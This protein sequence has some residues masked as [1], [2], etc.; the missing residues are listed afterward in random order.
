MSSPHRVTFVKQLDGSPL[1]GLSCTCA[2]GAMAL[3]RETIGAKRT[4]GARVRQLT[5]DSSGGTTLTQVVAAL[6]RG[7]SVSLT[8][9]TPTSIADFDNRLHA[10]QGAILQGS[11]S[12]TRG[13]RYQASETFG[14]NHAWFV[15]QGRGWRLTMGVWVPTEYLVFDP[16]AD[17]RRPDIAVSPF[18]LPR[19]YL[20]TFAKR[21]DLTGRGNLLGPGKV[22]AAFTRDTEPHMHAKYGGKQTTPFPDR[23][24]GK[25]PA[26]RKVNVRAT[27]STA[28]PIVEML[29]IGELFIAYQKTTTGQLH[30]GSRI[31]Y[32]DHDGNRWVHV[33]GLS[34]TG[35]TT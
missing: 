30:A 17:A 19:S 21:L 8:T 32:G 24:L 18:W 12:A 34:R 2:A 28:A 14:G 27:P 20:L 15:N 25:A 16:L 22:Y 13:T 7:F 11:E 35:G 1:G 3:D 31:W 6:Q 29:A 10:G 5:G 4:T 9:K 33:S 23:T 26:G